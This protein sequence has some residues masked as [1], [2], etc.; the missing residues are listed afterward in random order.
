MP[1]AAS[2]RRRASRH[3]GSRIRPMRQIK[4]DRI[5]LQALQRILDSLGDI[6]SGK[7]L[8][9][10]SHVGADLGDDDDFVAVAAA[11]HPSADDGLRFAALVAR[12]PA[13]IG[14]GGIDRVQP[15]STKRSRMSNEV[16]SSAVQP[17]T[18]PPSTSG[19][20]S[21][22]VLPRRRFCKALLRSLFSGPSCGR[23]RTYSRKVTSSNHA[24][25]HL[26]AESDVSVTK[27]AVRP[28]PANG[29]GCQAL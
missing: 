7:V 17:N 25:K 10:L 29:R 24:L 3:R 1:P 16:F 6:G 15:A 19:A 18:L 13:R 12:N 28:L 14:I 23:R 27:Q 26:L 8:L 21:R 9:A 11:L 4:V 22:S 5:D 20:I 2:D